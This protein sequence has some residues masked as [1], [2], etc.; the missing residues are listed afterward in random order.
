MDKLCIRL[1]VFVT[2]FALT[3]CTPPARAEEAENPT[4]FS[5][6]ALLGKSINDRDVV[7]FISKNDCSKVNEILLC[8][9]AGMT[10]WLNADQIVN[11]VILYAASADGF[12]KYSG[13]LPFGLSFYDPMW[14]VQEKLRTL[15]AD[16]AVQQAGLPDESGTPDRFHYWAIYK[17]LGMTVI[18]N[19]PAADEDAYIYAIL[20]S[21]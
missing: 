18:Y 6:Q 3:A 8:E 4:R 14:K 9:P 16:G 1:S 13:K 10:L 5:Y 7:D 20:V 21:K 19:S 17:R 15:D 12:T 2:L 11:T